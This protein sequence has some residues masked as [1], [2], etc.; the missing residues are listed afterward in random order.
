MIRRFFSLLVLICGAISSLAQSD[1]KE[2]THYEVVPIPFEANPTALPIVVTEVFSYAC[3]HCYDFQK[4]LQKW[5]DKQNPEQVKFERIH[6]VFSRDMVNLARAYIVSETLGVTESI[7][8]PLFSAIHKNGLRMDREDLLLR[9]FKGQ[10][11]VSYDDFDEVF[12]SP[13]VTQKMRDNNG[14]VRVWRILATPTMVVDGR[15]TTTPTAVNSK[16][17]VLDV[18]D[19]LVQKVL[20]ERE[21]ES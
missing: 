15:F 7:H 6:V 13:D 14:K 21:S 18:V 17:K 12:T 10:A 1:F 16:S 20:A 8:M 2:G 9:L 11:D 3:P 5:L 4:H 19:F